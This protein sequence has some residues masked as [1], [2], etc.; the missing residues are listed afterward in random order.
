MAVPGEKPMAVDTARD[1]AVGGAHDARR[2]AA[3]GM[4]ATVGAAIATLAPP[5]GILSRVVTPLPRRPARLGRSALR[6]RLRHRLLALRTPKRP[7]RDG[8][9]ARAEARLLDP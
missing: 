6:W 5:A 3:G 9:L 2:R 7:S 1:V 4:A 8:W